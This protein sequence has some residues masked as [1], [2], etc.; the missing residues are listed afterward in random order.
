MTFDSS[1]LALALAVFPAAL[2]AAGPGAHSV[3][4]PTDLALFSIGVAG[5]LIGRRAA[6][7]RRRKQPKD[8][9]DSKS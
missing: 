4:E 7:K 5:L 2:L 9:S 8:D 1:I 3:P 6:M